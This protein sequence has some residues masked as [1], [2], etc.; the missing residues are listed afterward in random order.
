MKNNLVHS[1]FVITVIALLV[2]LT[3]S[4]M[5]WM[6]PTAIVTVVFMAVIGLGVWTGFIIKEK[7]TDEREATHRMLSGRIAYLSGLGVLTAGLVVQGFQ[8]HVDPWVAAALGVMIVSKLL[9]N[10]YLEKNR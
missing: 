5:Y 4:F 6:P 1:L 10:I 7:A 3:D 2:L 8:H 9:A